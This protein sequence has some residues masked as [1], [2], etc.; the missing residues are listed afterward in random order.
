MQKKYTQSIIQY[1]LDGTLIKEFENA[2]QTKSIIHYDALIN[3]CLNKTKTAGGYVW[4]FK[5]D[6][7][8]LSSKRDKNNTI[9]CQICSSH[10]STRSMAMHLKW[11]HNIKTEEYVQQY[12]EFRPKE[13]KKQQRQKDSQIECALCS[14]K[15]VSNS[16][17]MYHL[18]ITHPEITKSE[19]II[20]YMLD[21]KTPTCKCGCGE[22]VTIL[23]NGK[24]CDLDKDTYHRDYIKGHWDWEVFSNI[25]HQSKEE[26][27]LLSF[28]QSI[29]NGKIRTSVKN[30]ISKAEIDIYLPELNIGI[31]YNG[32]YWHSEKNNRFRDYHVSKLKKANDKGIRLIQIFSDEWI[33]KRNIVENK[34][35][36]IIIKEKTKRTYARNCTVKEIDAKTKNQFLNQH[37]IQ[38]EDRSQIKLG[39]FYKDELISVMTFS[40]PRTALGAKVKTKGKYELS[41]FASKQYVVGGANK[42][43]RFFTR[44]Y[45]VN[46]IYSYSDNRWTDPKNNMYLNIGFTY[47]KTSEPNYFYT[48]D[49]QIRYHRYNFNKHK[50]KEMGAD[51]ATKTEKEIMKELGYTRVWDCGTTRYSLKFYYLFHI[52]I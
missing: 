13:L 25:N 39:L 22:P 10:E 51:V 35:K 27:D 38:G 4:R 24:N 48:K 18:S 6:D 16:S 31:E 33:N 49:Y 41:R 29:Y 30:A 9:Q 5:G 19:Y 43:I 21:N 7:F 17:L 42:M 8:S 1:S 23:E 34:L 26:L 3:C 32:L 36:S 47:D 52:Y 12:G 28:I 40:N 50:L 20:K 2:Q 45:T 15:L 14:E 37:H 44:L 11:V 46:E